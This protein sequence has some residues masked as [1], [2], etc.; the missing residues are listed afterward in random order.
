MSFDFPLWKIVRSSVILLLPLLM[1]EL[2]V[3]SAI[4][5]DSSIFVTTT[6]LLFLHVKMKN[7]YSMLKTS[8]IVQ[9]RTMQY[10]ANVSKLTVIVH[11]TDNIFQQNN[12]ST[13]KPFQMYRHREVK[14]YNVLIECNQL[15]NCQHREVRMFWAKFIMIG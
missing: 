13:Q 8:H 12:C 3:K 5:R 11:P 15:R 9:Y 7:D 14:L 2:I 6:G 10:H 4:S 1:L